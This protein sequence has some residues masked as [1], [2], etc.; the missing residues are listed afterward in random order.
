MG[1]VSK[2][3]PVHLARRDKFY[4]KALALL[5][6]AS[7][8][9]PLSER[10]WR[11]ETLILYLNTAYDEGLYAQ[12][13]IQC[14]VLEE[15]FLKVLEL[16]LDSAK[17]VQAMVNHENLLEEDKSFLNQFLGESFE[18]INEDEYIYRERA[19]DIIKGIQALTRS[20]NGAFEKVRKENLKGLSKENS[21]RYEKTAT[22]L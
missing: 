17:A 14:S 15:N 13:G 10:V 4:E 18:Q 7:F 2:N 6:E 9:E 12:R 21:I 19:N 3:R 16:V 11:I 8:K 5:A 1:K 22:T 20:A